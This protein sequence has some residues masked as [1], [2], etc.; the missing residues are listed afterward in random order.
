M[1]QAFYSGTAGLSAH[2]NSLDVISNN[3][4]NVNTNGYK[5][6]KQDFGS[7]LYASEVRPET[8]N[9]DNLLAGAGASLNSVKTD[10]SHGNIDI[11]E[12]NTDF[13]IEGD[14]FF[15]VRDNAGNTYYT[16]D[17]GFQAVNTGNGM[18]LGTQDGLAVLDRYGNTIPVTEEGP[19]AMPGV[20]AFTNAPGL[21]SAGQNLFIANNVSGPAVATD[22]LPRQGI[23]ERSNVNLANEMV[24]LIVSQRGY[25]LNANVVTTAD[26]IEQMIN[27]LNA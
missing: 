16:K 12:D 6:K 11:T 23:V 19:Q 13:Y 27:D 7:L 22:E 26:Q 21:L 8:R 14:G 17:G 25:Q 5:T 4:A 15:A 1:I 10:M 20:Y 9:S 3:V 2:Q 18:I 24:N